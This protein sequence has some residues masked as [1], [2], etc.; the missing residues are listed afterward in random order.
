MTPRHASGNSVNASYPTASPHE[1][2]SPAELIINDVRVVWNASAGAIS[3]AA[4]SE[5]MTWATRWYASLLA[6]ASSPATAAGLS[7]LLRTL[8]ATSAEA[9]WEYICSFPSFE[10]GFAALS[11]N[12]AASGWGDI[13]LVSFEHSNTSAVFRATDTP[14]GNFHRDTRQ[15][16]SSDLLAGRLAA[17]CGKAFGTSCDAQ[18][19]AF[20][21]R[22]DLYDQ[23]EIF[24]CEAS[25]S[26]GVTHTPE[27]VNSRGNSAGGTGVSI[28]QPEVERI[29]NEQFASDLLPGELSESLFRRI[30]QTAEEGVW[31]ID[32][33]SRTTFVNPKMASMLGYKAEEMIGRT[34]TDFMD[35][36]A[37]DIANSNVVRRRE[38]VSEQHD[39]LFRHKNGSSV[40]TLINTNPLTDSDGAYAGALAMISDI[41]ARKTAEQALIASESKM[42]V[43]INSTPD[44]IFFKDGQG[45]WMLVNE[46][47][48]NLFLL[49]DVDYRGKTDSQLAALIPQRREALLYCAASDSEAWTKHESS[50]S[51]EIIGD[52]GVPPRH[53]D[54]I[55]I[56]LYNADRSRH[57]LVIV[58]RDITDSINTAKERER[59]QAMLQQSQKVE[60][61]G[62]LAG[63]VA[64]DFNNMLAVILGYADLALAKID[65]NSPCADDLRHIRTAAEHSSNLTR[66]L[67]TYARKQPIN[68]RPLHLNAAITNVL[69]MLRRLIGDHI[70]IVWKSEAAPDIITA[71]P[72]QIDQILANLAINARDAMESG[73]TLTIATSNLTVAASDPSA[74][75]P[76]GA[77]L[78][79]TVS[80]SGRGMAPETLERLFEPF[81]S[82]KEIGRG[83]GLGCALVYG[84]VRQNN[85]WIDVESSPGSGTTFTIDLP[86]D[87]SANAVAP[88]SPPSPIRSGGGSETILLVEDDPAVLNLVRAVL[89]HY[90][91][92]V[93]DTQNALQAM[94]IAREHQD[95]IRLLISDVMMPGI[96]GVDLHAKLKAIVPN[97]K[98][99]LMSGYVADHVAQLSSHS[100]A[101]KFLQ[102]PFSPMVLAATVRETLD[103]SPAESQWS[104]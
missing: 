37:R 100:S 32:A 86:L 35:D 44:V 78:R 40:W 24:A 2:G 92:R 55:K 3:L 1:S 56:P 43:L 46:S 20:V 70:G 13:Q 39:F 4:T 99:I 50:R 27:R 10:A 64:H 74:P 47:A 101:A 60:S 5:A 11:M 62:R 97:I 59:L 89:Q 52:V 68:P 34:F 42:K 38:G 23:F 82:T 17:L 36:A 93:L 57:G 9:D 85:G 63:G 67:L 12:A 103:R 51:V 91:Y 94:D 69:A 48:R 95:Q 65:P 53:F 77:Y 61:I 80:D 30:V 98:V 58:G 8:G 18:Q 49:G 75:L 31:L 90:G 79:L 66:Q 76:A 45:R 87:R 96:N 28:Q 71:D 29:A 83:T 6:G 33:N 73:G 54:V 19:T 25:F 84:I 15:V 41:T 21:A 102:K 26:G 22:G 72:M 14:E 104:S 16:R 7:S 88:S 81:Y